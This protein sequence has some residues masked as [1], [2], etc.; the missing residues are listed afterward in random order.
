MDKTKRQFIKNVSVASAGIGVGI[1][2]MP[3]LARAQHPTSEG[4][5]NTVNSST[6][7]L[8]F[9]TDPAVTYAEEGFIDL[10]IFTN[11]SAAV[12]LEYAFDEGEYTTHQSVTMGLADTLNTCHTFRLQL[13]KTALKVHYRF[14]ARPCLNDEWPF[15]LGRR[16]ISNSTVYTVHKNHEKVAFNV[17]NDLHQN[18]PVIK[19]LVTQAKKQPSDF[20]LLNGDLITEAKSESQVR[21]TIYKQFVGID[22]NSVLHFL[23]GNHECRGTHA[24]SMHRYL[25][26]PVAGQ[27]YYTFR[28]GPVQ[29][30]MLD[31]GEDKPD[32]WDD[33]QGLADFEAYREQELEWIKTVIQTPE[34][35]N[36]PFRIV[37]CH[38]PIW[39]HLP[40]KWISEISRSFQA[41]WLKVLTSAGVDLMLAGHTHIYENL[42]VGFPLIVGGG[43]KAG[44]AT[45]IY[46]EADSQLITVNITN[47]DGATLDTLSYGVTSA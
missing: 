5:E 39:H 42:D 19:R 27:N 41:R 33:Y 24:R 11:K 44:A 8:V 47:D 1:A 10:I 12:E 23:R 14:L 18:N 25:S 26:T 40:T 16:I 37:C 46:V 28:Q 35:K 38:I 31:T 4:P 30:L 22:S 32:F 9:V 21:D 34:W 7:T 17:F 3:T 36:A 6:D 29:F 13:A 45:R 15:K 20:T 43:P 2:L